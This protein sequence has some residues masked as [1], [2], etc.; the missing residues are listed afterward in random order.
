MPSDVFPN[1]VKYLREKAV[2]L[3]EAAE[4]C[5]PEIAAKL[6]HL[7]DEFEAYATRLERPGDGPTAHRNAS[8]PDES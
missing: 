2:R 8:H 3:R 5:S 7:A 6:L 1:Q 4:G